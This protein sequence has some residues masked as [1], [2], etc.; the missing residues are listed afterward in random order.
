MMITYMENGGN[1][2]IICNSTF[3]IG[4]SARWL[5]LPSSPRPFVHMMKDSQDVTTII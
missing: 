5:S 2:H 4:L 3:I 1:L